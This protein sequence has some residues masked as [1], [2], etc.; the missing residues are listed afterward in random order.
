LADR[1]PP[2][3]ETEATMRGI[4][5]AEFSRPN[6]G[7]RLVL[8]R[9]WKERRGILQT[10]AYVENGRPVR[11]RGDKIYLHEVTADGEVVLSL[12]ELD[13]E[14]AALTELRAR[15]AADES[16]LAAQVVAM[17]AAREQWA[18]ERRRRLRGAAMIQ[19]RHDTW[20]LA[21]HTTAHEKRSCPLIRAVRRAVRQ[22]HDPCSGR[23]S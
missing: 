16:S 12:R 19:R 7:R 14:I 2:V 13:G 15:L 11:S 20:T 18:R 17:R 6:G 8:L 23:G 10:L 21:R 4:L 22:R 9:E 5:L 1:E 3:P